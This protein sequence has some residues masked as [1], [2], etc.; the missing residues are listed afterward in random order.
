MSNL[1]STPAGFRAMHH[2][3][4]Q[5]PTASSS[6]SRRAGRASARQMESRL[7]ANRAE[8]IK[9]SIMNGGMGR[10]M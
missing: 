4:Q 3:T 7:A 5:E 10:W 9:F 6:R 2:K 1:P 8:V